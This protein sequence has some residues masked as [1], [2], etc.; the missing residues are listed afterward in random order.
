MLTPGG[1]AEQGYKEELAYREE[2]ARREV[3]VEAEIRLTAQEAEARGAEALGGNH[4]RG[5]G[6]RVGTCPSWNLFH[7][8]PSGHRPLRRRPRPVCRRTRARIRVRWG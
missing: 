3:G 6:R 8:G 1:I 7:T 2:Q 4:R 5:R